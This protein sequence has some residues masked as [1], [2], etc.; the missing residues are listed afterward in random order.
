MPS[1]QCCVGKEGGR[2]G[3]KGRRSRD[4]QQAM[5]EGWQKDG[6]RGGETE[7]NVC[8]LLPLCDPITS[9][10]TVQPTALTKHPKAT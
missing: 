5:T 9:H 10:S 4:D 1:A 3:A 7:Q 2:G 6:K 8:R